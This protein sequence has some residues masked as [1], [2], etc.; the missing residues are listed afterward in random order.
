M[1]GLDVAALRAGA[2]E[3]L[4]PVLSGAGPQDCPPAIGAAVQVGLARHCGVSMSVLMPY[5]DRLRLFA[6][7]YVQLWAESLGKGGQGTTPIAAAGPVDQHSQMQLFL[8]GPRDKLLTIVTLEAADSG[9]RTD[10]AYA[11]D[12]LVGYLAGT[13]VGTLVDCEQRAAVETLIRNAR[14][15]RHIHLETLD[16]TSMGA[17]LMHF[18]LETIIAG[19]LLG[20]DPFDQP[21]VEESKV[22]TRDY[23][24][25]M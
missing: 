24:T 9:P 1:L 15:T 25:G 17:L 11:K 3:V 23:L 14:P 4:E 5:T 7:W 6:N 13:S 8:D 16:E 2:A 20:V 10:Q 18:M 21:A 19:H 22:L 12:P